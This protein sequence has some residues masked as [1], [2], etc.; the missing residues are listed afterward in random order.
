MFPSRTWTT[1][2]LLTLWVA[3]ALAQGT[4]LA[5]VLAQAPVLAPFSAATSA[6]A[7]APWRAVGL[8]Q[9]K[10][11]LTR[12]DITT[13]DGTRVLRLQTDA[14]YG[15]LV[16]ATPAWTPGADSTL[17][18]RWRLEQALAK[19]DLRRKEGDDAA[20]KVCV[21]YDMPL[22][23]I[24]FLERSLLRL[25][26]SVSGEALPSA[27]VCYVWDTTLPTGTAL[28]NIY[29][30]RVRYIVLDGSDSAPGQWRNHSRNLAADFMRLFRAESTQVPPITAVAVG[31]DAD[32]T[33]GRSLAYIGDIQLKP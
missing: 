2:G 10:A 12:M 13:L 30:A 4:A 16:H 22:G 29:S 14:S 33:G 28:A 17:Q 19:P 6:D 24:P 25:A 8:P 15:T 27:T 32:N 11:P 20:L 9:G 3:E 26:R 21:M 1:T 31:A 18:W 5:P 7:P 23:G